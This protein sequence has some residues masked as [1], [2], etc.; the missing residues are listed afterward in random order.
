[1]PTAHRK[2]IG[3]G[4][5][6][7]KIGRL[8]TDTE[9]LRVR[10]PAHA[11][12]LPETTLL[13]TAG[14]ALKVALPTIAKGVIIRRPRMVALA[15]ALNLDGLAV[16]TVQRLRGRYGEGPLLLRGLR[17]ALVLAPDDLRRVL[18]E[19]PEP[20]AAAS[21]EKVAAL[22]HFEPR[23]AL[24]THGPKREPRRTLNER[25]LET[26]RPTHS[27]VEPLVTVVEY[28]MGTLFDDTVERGATIDWDSFNRAWS[29]MVRGVVLGSD[30]RNDEA[31]T[32]MLERLRGRVNWAFFASKDKKLRL[33]FHKL[34]NEHLARAEAGSLAACIAKVSTSRDEAP[35]HQVAQWLFAFDP[36]GMATFRTL[37]FLATHPEQLARAKREAGDRALRREGQLPY[38][39]ACFLEA[40]RLW[41][42]TPM[43][44]RQT[45]AETNWER[46]RMPKDTS[47]LIFA[48]F[49]HRDEERLPFA[50]RFA[51]DV[52]LDDNREWPLVP[53]SGG[54][55][56]CPAHN[57]VPMIASAALAA[58]LGGRRPVLVKGAKLGPEA[59]LPGTLDNYALRFRMEHED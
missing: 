3:A 52:W 40:L 54:T 50:H 1:M 2:V 59:P 55:A 20:F 58:L 13:E 31:L 27:L 45:T 5:N 38:L 30:A 34:L 23:V 42:T 9:E 11:G 46:G 43:I 21:D 17:R 10:S 22:A 14:V 4:G 47:V 6:L 29:R 41:P 48:P 28:E 37:A 7:A 36:A 56:I 18:N 44:L 33:Q 19:T 8:A 32:D 57:F 39:R 16:R 53:F 25:A 26:D 35:S 49:F 51:P 12:K 24:A 15:E